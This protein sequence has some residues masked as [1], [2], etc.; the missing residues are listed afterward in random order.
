MPH[1]DLTIDFNDASFDTSNA[2]TQPVPGVNVDVVLPISDNANF[3]AAEDFRA[4]TSSPINSIALMPDQATAGVMEEFLFEFDNDI[5]N[6]PNTQDPGLKITTEGRDNNNNEVIQNIELAGTFNNLTDGGTL[7]VHVDT[8]LTVDHDGNANTAKIP[9]FQKFSLGAP[10]ANSGDDMAILVSGDTNGA[11]MGNGNDMAMINVDATA[12]MTG[13]YKGGAGFDVLT[14]VEGVVQDNGALV[15]FG[16]GISGDVNSALVTNYGGTGSGLNFFMSEFE[17][18]Q[19]TNNADTIIIGSKT[20]HG[21]TDKYDAAYLNNGAD[22]SMIELKSGY[23]DGGAADVMYINAGSNIKLNFDFVNTDQGISAEFAANGNVTVDDLGGSGPEIDVN[24]TKT[25]GTGL[26]IDYLEGTENKDVVVNKGT[27]GVTVD[28]GGS[29]G[30]ADVFTGSATSGND[31]LD[32]R[33]AHDLSF[34]D[35]GNGYIEVKSGTD[36]YAELKDVDYIMV[37]DK[38]QGAEVTQADVKLWDDTKTSLENAKTSA[39]T[40]LSNATNPGS[41][42]IT[43]VTQQQIDAYAALVKA[44]SDTNTALRNAT[45]PGNQVTETVTQQMID[46]YKAI[47]DAEAA[48]NTALANGTDPG[49]NTPI[50]AVTQ[51]MIDDYKA[52]VDAEAA[53]NTA[54]ANGTNPGTNT[55]IAAVTQQMIDDYAALVKAA[56]DAASALQSHTNTSRPVLTDVDFL[57]DMT[58]LNG[59]KLMGSLGDGAKDAYGLGY[60]VMTSAQ[61]DS[62]GTGNGTTNLRVY[63]EGDHD[64]FVDTDDNVIVSRENGTVTMSAGNSTRGS[65]WEGVIEGQYGPGQAPGFYIEVSQKKLAV[66]FDK[67]KGEWKVD[68]SAI[69]VA[70]NA[71]TAISAAN[72]SAKS[73]AA[74]ATKVASQFGIQLKANTDHSGTA[75]SNDIYLNATEEAITELLG[76]GVQSKS[77]NFDFY[78]KVDLKA[79]GG[80]VTVN[81][82][83][84]ESSGSFTL[85]FADLDVAVESFHN[86][87]DNAG[88]AITSSSAAGEFVKI[89]NAG[90]IALGNGGDDTYVIGAD[91]SGLYGGVALEYGNIGTSGGLTGSVDAVNINSV[92]SVDDLTFRRGKYRNEEDGSTLFIADK[93]GGNETVLFDNYN[94]YLDFRRV[95]YLTVEDGA[96][97]NEVYEIVT[98]KNLSDWDNEIY[99]AD[100]GTSHVMV[101]GDDYVIGSSKADTVKLILSDIIGGS[102]D[103]SGTIDLS[104]LTD[105]DTVAIDGTVLKNQADLVTKLQ[106]GIDSGKDGKATISF[107]KSAD[108]LTVA[109]DNVDGTTYDFTTTYEFIA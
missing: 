92:D 56:S 102:A 52:I 53:A 21:L 58:H 51:Q 38:A 48:A 74:L 90:D 89:D 37:R 23:T 105:A 2:N 8:G 35:A 27:I 47:V 49:T 97:N 70:E 79:E 61:V 7:D 18:L 20:G 95:E 42:V 100:G 77:Y 14:L 81:V 57:K 50:A 40:A 33:I 108:T 15:D 87:A 26:A 101:G 98:S 94:N 62:F 60:D 86:V 63:Y 71:D 85:D 43:G 64:D 107:D 17:T 36:V 34:K 46:D 68:T 54:L 30:D 109:Y 76:G 22:N 1:N 104:G 10:T 73:G 78:T 16:K 3:G 25:G 6:N 99:V 13:T 82:K 83:L 93:N 80:D 84:A 11:N 44:E 67:T 45:D 55:P 29:K 75:I 59:T 24:I 31:M 32:A 65:S 28:L 39:D 69:Q 19:L 12:D 106:A 4:S 88:A 66:T 96:N 5:D 41:S 91:N 9:V 103:A 72:G